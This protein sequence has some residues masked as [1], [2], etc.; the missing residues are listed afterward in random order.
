MVITQNN[1]FLERI[2][3][4]GN[5]TDTVTSRHLQFKLWL[6]AVIRVPLK[7]WFIFIHTPPPLP[8]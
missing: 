3:R 2:T 4:T 7:I 8:K 1:G 6:M 5:I